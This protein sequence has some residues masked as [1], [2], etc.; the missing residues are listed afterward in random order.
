MRRRLF[1]AHGRV[2]DQALVGVQ[3]V[4]EKQQRR[5]AVEDN[6]MHSKQC[7]PLVLALLI[8]T[9]L[10]QGVAVQGQRGLA[11]AAQALQHLILW[12]APDLLQLQIEV[13]HGLRLQAGDALHFVQPT[14]QQ[15]ITG[16]HL[17]VSIAQRRQVQR[18][19]TV[20]AQGNLVGV[21]IRQGLVQRP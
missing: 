6:M 16:Q 5:G 1:Q 11:V 21:D 3:Q 9:P 19:V 15:R 12:H 4:V 2:A 8:D 10:D 20:K 17:T 18:L 14:G 7:P 13:G